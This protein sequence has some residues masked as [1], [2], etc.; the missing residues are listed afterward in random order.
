MPSKA[1]ARKARA[2]ARKQIMTIE[3]VALGERKPSPYAQSTAE[4]RLAA[5][6]RLIEHH[7]AL[8]GGYSGLPRSEWPGETIIAG[9][10]RD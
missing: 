3:V 9:E 2:A 7:Q 4:E 1:E 5:A 10:E 6:V 8:R